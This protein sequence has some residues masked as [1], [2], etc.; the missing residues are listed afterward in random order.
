[1]KDEEEETGSDVWFH[2]PSLG[3]RQAS[4]VL[5]SLYLP[6]ARPPQKICPDASDVHMSAISCRRSV[7]FSVC[8]NEEET[9]SS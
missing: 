7:C 4:A 6:D 5:P 1:M 8:A 9:P 3:S 2:P